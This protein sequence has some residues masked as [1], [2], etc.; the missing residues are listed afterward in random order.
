[1]LNKLSVCS[2]FSKKQRLHNTMKFCL[3]VVSFFFFFGTV[4]DDAVASYS[5]V[6]FI[7]GAT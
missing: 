1:M 6:V 2:C 7:P 3:S 5:L 4:K